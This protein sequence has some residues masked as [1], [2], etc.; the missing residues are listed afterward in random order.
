[1]GIYRVDAEDNYIY[2]N[3]YATLITGIRPT[4]GSKSLCATALH[5]EDIERVLSELTRCKTE[6]CLFAQ[7]YRFV[8][9][10]G[11]VVWVY[12]QILPEY[13]YQGDCIGFLGTIID[14]TDRKEAEK[15]SKISIKNSK[16]KLNSVQRSYCKPIVFSKQFS[17]VAV[18]QLFLLMLMELFKL[19]TKVQNFCWVILHQK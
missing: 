16:L 11:K 7:E 4:L 14:I 15:N 6:K 3:E 17:I 9:P 2:V 1:V 8:H 19:L 13:N 5:P 18:I 10:D 12:G